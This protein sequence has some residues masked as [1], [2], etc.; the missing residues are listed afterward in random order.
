MSAP[1][2]DS[3]VASSDR[4]VHRQLAGELAASHS[5]CRPP[6]L[7]STI[8]SRSSRLFDLGQQRRHLFGLLI[9]RHAQRRLVGVVEEREQL[10][11]LALR[12][13]IVLVIVAAGAAHRQPQK[14]RAGRADPID[15]GLDAKLLRVGA[16]FLVDQR[17]AVKARGDRCWSSVALG[18]MSPASCSM[19]NWSNGKSRFMAAITQSRYFQ[20]ERPPS[21]V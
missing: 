19:V 4:P 17:V 2:A 7:A 18:S 5:A 3:A 15:H 9:G 10:I 12:D 20:I 14:R 11:E 21:I 13:R 8:A 6:E 1:P 16:P